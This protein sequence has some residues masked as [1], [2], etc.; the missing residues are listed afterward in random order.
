[1]Y[2][3]SGLALAWSTNYPLRTK[4]TL[5][6]RLYVLVLLGL[7]EE[8]EERGGRWRILHKLVV[9]VIAAG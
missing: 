5:K 2:F 6:V 8:E 1:M 4:K 3:E 9:V 7:E